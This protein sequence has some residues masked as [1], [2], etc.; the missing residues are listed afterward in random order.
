LHQWFGVAFSLE[1]F[2][3][4]TLVQTSISI[5]WAALALGTM[6][7]AARRSSRIAWLAGATLLTVVVAKLFLVDLSRI[8]SIERIVSFVGVG[9]LMLLV[10]YWSPLPPAVQARR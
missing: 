6:L 8:G 10:G 1:S 9:L 7:I 5:F 4:S 3:R 2:M